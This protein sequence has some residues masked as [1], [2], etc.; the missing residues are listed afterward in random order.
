MLQIIILV[1]LAVVGVLGSLFLDHYMSYAPEWL[2]RVLVCLYIVL[3]LFVAVTSRLIYPYLRDYRQ[4]PLLSTILVA[5]IAA[6]L[7]GSVWGIWVIGFPSEKRDVDTAELAKTTTLQEAMIIDEFRGISGHNANKSEMLALISTRYKDDPTSIFKLSEESE[8]NDLIQRG[9]LD[10][11]KK[12]ATKSVDVPEF[13]GRPAF[14]VSNVFITQKGK[15]LAKD[16]LYVRS[17]PDLHVFR[18]HE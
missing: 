18:P 11:T 2:W 6:A 10:H 9:I 13:P 1:T 15:N 8:L 17:H 14:V 7:A 5:I 3:V 4:H 12:I 16:L